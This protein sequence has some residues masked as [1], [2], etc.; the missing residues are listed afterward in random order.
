MVVVCTEIVLDTDA[1]MYVII[2]LTVTL[3]MFVFSFRMTE[4]IYRL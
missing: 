3:C 4:N 1:V 2:T